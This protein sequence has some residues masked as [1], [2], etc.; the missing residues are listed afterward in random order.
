MRT[1]PLSVQAGVSNGVQCE[2]T[3][4]KSRCPGDASMTFDS[5][6]GGGSGVA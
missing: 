6:W 4:Q 1:P 2:R 5:R 3:G